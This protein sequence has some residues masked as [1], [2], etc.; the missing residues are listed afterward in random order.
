MQE[1]IDKYGGEKHLQIPDELKQQLDSHDIEAMESINSL[2]PQEFTV[3]EL[4]V[5]PGRPQG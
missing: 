3:P 2:K 1:L 4:N 5:N